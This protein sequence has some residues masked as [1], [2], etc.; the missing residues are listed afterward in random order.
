[1]ACLYQLTFPNGKK[2]IGITVKTAEKRA[3]GHR[4]VARSGGKAAVS[5]AI[6]KYEK[7][8]CKTLVIADIDYLKGLE[9]KVIASFGTLAPNGYNLSFGGD[10]SPFSN[11][12]VAAK[13]KGNKFASREGKPRLVRS[14]AYLAKLSSALKGNK[15]SQGN[16]HGFGNKNA[17]GPRTEIHRQNI[18]AGV[19]RAKALRESNKGEK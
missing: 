4:T 17:T 9:V 10:H 5:E 16:S 2:Y 13:A 15:N 12:D 7:F 11:P 8:E 6:R 14:A 3:Q 19:A 18:K 1:M